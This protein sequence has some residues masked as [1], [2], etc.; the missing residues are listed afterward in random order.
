[1]MILKIEEGDNLR[2]TSKWLLVLLLLLISPIPIYSLWSN[3]DVITTWGNFAIP[4]LPDLNVYLRTYI[5]IASAI[6]IVVW[7]IYLLMVLFRATNKKFNLIKKSY[8]QVQVSSKAINNFI[9]ASL[10]DEPLLNNPKVSSKL[11]NRQLNIKI[12]GQL[13]AGEHA[14]QQFERYLEQLHHNLQQLLGIQQKPVINIR[15]NGY[16]T[17]TAGSPKMRVQ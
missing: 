8:G 16:Q 7:L 1:M 12:D 6:F 3:S 4:A 14:Q 11:T 17:K 15:F 10:K 9:I 13:L 5:F 2:K